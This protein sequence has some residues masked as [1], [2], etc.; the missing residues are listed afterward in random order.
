MYTREG[1]GAALAAVVAR[2]AF[3]PSAGCFAVV[4]LLSHTRRTADER[5]AVLDY[6]PAREAVTLTAA[7]PY[8]CEFQVLFGSSR[9]KH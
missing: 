9:C 3:L 8:R 5:G 1:F 4:P 7:R 2:A 6:D